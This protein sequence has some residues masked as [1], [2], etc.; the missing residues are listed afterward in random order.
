MDVIIDANIIRRDLK[1][2]DKGFEILIDYLNKTNSKLIFPS[3][4]IEEVK[5][6][7]KRVLKERFEEY[8]K[9]V[10]KLKSTL[11]FIEMPNLPELDIE[12]DSEKYLDFIHQKFG[13]NTS[14]IIKYKNDYLPEL[15][16]RAVERK[17]PLDEKGQQFRDG[18]LWLT[19]LDYA[20]TI[21]EKT[22]AFISDNPSDFCEK[23]KTELAKELVDEAT[24]RGITIKFY[25]TLNDFAKQQASTIEFINKDWIEKHL[26]FR[27]MEQMFIEVLGDKQEQK[28]IDS[29]NLERNEDPTGYNSWTGY[30][31]SWFEEFFVYEKTDGTLLLN[32]ELEI[33]TEFEVEIERTIDRDNSR[34]EYVWKPNPITG[35]PEMEMDFIVDYDY[36]HE[37]TYKHVNPIF[38][39]KFVIPIKNEKIVSYDLKGW[40]WG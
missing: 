19:L 27:T 10:D 28:I 35:E 23:G 38:R 39:A 13:T 31:N 30:V 17:K 7:Y 32:L 4:V 24:S 34:Y 25:K 2:S 6:L 14:N 29:L 36:N 3:I 11:L 18:L 12:G 9:S 22:V 37:N 26:D 1:L 21:E 8:N 15:V 20:E 33:E 16:N 5:S 40:E